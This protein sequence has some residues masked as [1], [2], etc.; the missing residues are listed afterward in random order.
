MNKKVKLLLS[1]IGFG[2]GIYLLWFDYSFSVLGEHSIG[3]TVILETPIKVL[4]VAI[5][6]I[7]LGVWGLVASARRS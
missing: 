6:L 1:L 3:K 5:G 7:A 2:A 4:Y